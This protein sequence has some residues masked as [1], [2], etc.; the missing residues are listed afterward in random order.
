VPIHFW[1]QT[2]PALTTAHPNR[3]S[4]G[5]QLGGDDSTNVPDATP[6]AGQVRLIEVGA[7]TGAAGRG[8]AESADPRLL[9]TFHGTF[10][11]DGSASADTRL[12]FEIAGLAGV[13][14]ATDGSS[15]KGFDPECI[16]GVDS[17]V[18]TFV[19][20]EFV[21]PL[22]FFLDTRSEGSF[23]EIQ[24]VASI[25]S[26]SSETELGRSAVLNLPI[27]RVHD[28]T[29]TTQNPGGGN[30]TY[31]GRVIGNI[32]CHHE[33]Y[34]LTGVHHNAGSDWPSQMNPELLQISLTSS[35]DPLRPQIPFAPY[36]AG[37]LKIIL[38]NTLIDGI[39]TLLADAAAHTRARSTI[40][41]TLTGIFTD[42][43]FTGVQVLW[44]GDAA[45]STDLTAFRGS[46]QDSG[47]GYVLSGTTPLAIPF[48]TFFVCRKS[49]LESVGV[50]EDT[51]Y[52]STSNLYTTHGKEYLLPY[53]TP[54]GS[55]NKKLQKPIYV[56]TDYFPT[57][58]APSIAPL[59]RGS[60][61]PAPDPNVAID[62]ASAKIGIVIAHEVGHAIGL[63]HDL[64]VMDSG[65]YDE[66]AASPI[67][68]V[69]SSAIDSDA[70]GSTMKFSNQAK[71]IWQGAFGVSP[72][73][74]EPYLVNKTWSASEW[75]TLDWTDRLHRF[76]VQNHAD[77]MGR[78]G[79]GTQLMGTPPFTG[80]S[81]HEQR[82]TYVAS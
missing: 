40:Q 68:T 12:T 55:G 44:E 15:V 6:P 21:I 23:M 34:L 48:W 50:A 3:F 66:S 18:V 73:W 36:S 67:L 81:G 32:I 37:S 78:P 72:T 77:S 38:L 25:G 49:S 63:M 43:G 57:V 70:F 7:P 31:H 26:G 82:G 14:I 33:D 65:P 19:N 46:F 59:R 11:R 75:A 13:G 4:I 42:A 17:V 9:A 35:T 60:P 64:M 52:D 47:D 61:P 74:A 30:M 20:R 41:Q 71:V 54:I 29:T 51:K 45:A 53:P 28:V 58:T 10:H 56:R 27:R 8:N 2:T 62:A 80:T 79:V 39:E 76:F 16:L 1:W 24:A 69:M 22:P 5:L